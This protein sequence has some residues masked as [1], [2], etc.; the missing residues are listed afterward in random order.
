M[1][2]LVSVLLAAGLVASMTACGGGDKKESA[3]AP[4]ET[5]AAAA[6]TTKADEK[7]T[8]KVTE[9]VTEAAKDLAD[10]GEISVLYYT[11][12]DTYISSVRSALD[13]AL[14]KAGIKYQ[15]YDSNNRDRKSVV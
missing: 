13:A 4:A 6:E 2:K 11:Y 7:E 12:G 10:A 5:T 1:K 9:A 3:A 15:D 8:E 14:D